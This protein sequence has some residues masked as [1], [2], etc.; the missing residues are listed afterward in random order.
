[1]YWDRQFSYS[2]NQSFGD[3]FT[4]RRLKVLYLNVRLFQRIQFLPLPWTSALMMLNLTYRNQP[5]TSISPIGVNFTA[6][7]SMSDSIT[8]NSSIYIS[9]GP[10]HDAANRAV[11]V[12]NL[13]PSLIYVCLLLLIGI[14]G[15]GLVIYVYLLKLNKTTSRVFILALG[16]YDFINCITDMTMEVALILN[17]IRFDYPVLCKVSRFITATINHGSTFVL[18]AI[19]VDR[20]RRICRIYKTNINTRQAKWIVFGSAGF[21]LATSWPTLYLYGTQTISISFNGR[22]VIGKTCLIKDAM[23]SS[24]LPFVFAVFLLSVHFIVDF[25][26]II[27]YTLIGRAVCRQRNVRKSIIFSGSAA[28][29]R[30]SMLQGNEDEIQTPPKNTTPRPL[31]FIQFKGSARKSGQRRARTNQK[32][33][34]LELKQSI[35]SRSSVHSEKGTFHAGKTT[36][37]LFL[38]TVGFVLSFLPHSI[39]VIIRYQDVNFY[40]RLSNSEKSV[41]QL[42]LRSYLFNSVLNPVVYCFVSHQFRQKS[43]EVLKS[44]FG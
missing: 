31:S 33:L 40:D 19:A 37:M 38:V 10:Y 29:L 6:T 28:Y 4:T 18:V 8:E 35:R 25:I 44:L 7:E 22:T 13:L 32:R 34:T 2:A 14:P 17:F 12:D 16:L 21:A 15:N 39:L 27:H 3:I 23:K 43:K 41:F 30:A 36:L 26:L 24:I 5:S 9:D 42:F 1:M 20:F 11:L